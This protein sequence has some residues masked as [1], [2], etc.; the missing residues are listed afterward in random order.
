M[1][2]LVI[3]A[4]QGLTPRLRITRHDTRG[5]AV[6]NMVKQTLMI[7]AYILYIGVLDDNAQN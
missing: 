7:D 5:Q 4:V 3:I 1:L 2:C 6:A